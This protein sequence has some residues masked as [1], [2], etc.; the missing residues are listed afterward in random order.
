MQTTSRL[1]PTQRCRGEDCRAEIRQVELTN[2]NRMPLDLE[3]SAQ[4]VVRV[5]PDGRG[6]VL[7]KARAAA[8]LAR[9]EQL[10]QTH[11]YSCPNGPQFRKRS[12]R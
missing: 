5:L 2:G 3:P 6:E 8:A 4:G 10:Y 9:G 7:T 12:R 1:T 11:F